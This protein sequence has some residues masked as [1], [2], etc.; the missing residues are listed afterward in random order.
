[1]FKMSHNQVRTALSGLV[2]AATTTRQGLHGPSSAPLSRA[3]PRT[4][5]KLTVRY[6]GREPH[7]GRHQFCFFFYKTQIL[8]TQL[9]KCDVNPQN[10]FFLEIG[11]SD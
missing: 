7:L 8:P 5:M 3:Q 1:M 6:I 2:T 9:T 4:V 11:K 10:S